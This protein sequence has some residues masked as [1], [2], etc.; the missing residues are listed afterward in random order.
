MEVVLANGDVVRTGQWAADGA[1]TAHLCKN[2]Y[3]PQIDGL[4]LQS[5]LGIVTKMSLWLQPRPESYMSVKVEV[6]KFSDLEPLMNGLA[7][8]HRADILQNN[9]LIGDVL[10]YLS[11]HHSAAELHPGPGAIPDRRIEELRREHHLGYW[12]AVFDFYGPS[13]MVL[14]RLQHAKAALLRHCPNS[15][16]QS[17]LFEGKDGMPLDSRDIART[18]R[19]EPV[20]LVGTSRSQMI[21]FATPPDGNG[22]GAHTDFVPLMPNDGKLIMKWFTESRQIMVKHGFN[23]ILGARIFKKHSF[24]IQM[25]TYDSSSQT[26]AEN[27]PRLW[28]GLAEAGKKY[29]LTNYRSHLDNMGMFTSLM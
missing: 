10:G 26:H 7:E 17:Q 8:L 27:L 18:T 24:T 2:S 11:I 21:N 9:P 12:N 6:D 25:I 5:N 13:D 20:G 23:P 19:G 29:K 14:L 1:P 15:K 4:F 16:I 3:G 28:K 22:H